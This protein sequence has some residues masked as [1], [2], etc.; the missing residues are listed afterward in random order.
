MV[1][2]RQYFIETIKVPTSSIRTNILHTYDIIQKCI[3]GKTR[4]NNFECIDSSRSLT[5]RKYIYGHRRPRLMTLT[6][7]KFDAFALEYNNIMQVTIL[8]QMLEKPSSYHAPDIVVN[9]QEQI[10]FWLSRRVS[11]RE[12][13][14]HRARIYQ[15]HNSLAVNRL[16]DIIIL[17]NTYNIVQV[18]ITFI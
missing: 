17:Y 18:F 8:R 3:N 5:Y 11:V 10:I 9:E 16:Y 4:V 1:G 15:V 7:H 13:W 2:R 12:I 14:T 6:N